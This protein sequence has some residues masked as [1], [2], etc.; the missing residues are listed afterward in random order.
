[1][2]WK[3]GKRGVW[4][5]GLLACTDCARPQ[6]LRVPSDHPAGDPGFHHGLGGGRRL[7]TEYQNPLRLEPLLWQLLL[8]T[9]H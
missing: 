2:R 4:G 3:P 1:M 6:F 8:E 9:D 5:A 7:E